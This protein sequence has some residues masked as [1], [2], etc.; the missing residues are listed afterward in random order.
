MNSFTFASPYGNTVT[1]SYYGMLVT[2]RVFGTP[3]RA[4]ERVQIPGMNGDLIIDQ[5]RYNNIIVAYEC[6]IPE[7]FQS[8]ILSFNQAMGHEMAQYGTLS[9]TYETGWYRRARFMGATSPDAGAHVQSGSLIVNFDCKPQKYKDRGTDVTV[10]ANTTITNPTGYEAWP[11]LFF[12]HGGSATFTNSDGESHTITVNNSVF[13]DY[14]TVV[15]DC[16]LKACYNAGLAN[17]NLNSYVSGI[18]PSLKAGTCTITVSNGAVF[19]IWPRWW[20]L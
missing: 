13:N 2:G 3:E 1:S 14:S 8:R 7:N 11:Q 4:I 5:G 19:K 12:T 9:D 10:N 20:K 15:V 16:E 6:G 18:F 17:V